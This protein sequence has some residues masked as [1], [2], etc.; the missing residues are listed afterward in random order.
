[1]FRFARVRCGALAAIGVL[2]VLAALPFTG[3]A[4]A[5]QR[6]GG[7]PEVVLLRGLFNIFSH[8]MDELS[9]KLAQVG[10]RTRVR[11]TRSGARLPMRS[12]PARRPTLGC[13]V[14][15]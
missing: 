10:V 15:F 1:M 13:D 12:S 2:T 7:Q 11:T 5:Q 9:A 4:Q 3:P 14:W 8:G 6:S